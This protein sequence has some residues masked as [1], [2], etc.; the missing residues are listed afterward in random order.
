MLAADD[1]A[2]LAD[3]DAE[4]LATEVSTEE[5]TET[6]ADNELDAP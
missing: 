4:L 6:E 2:E 3:E 5:P 1:T